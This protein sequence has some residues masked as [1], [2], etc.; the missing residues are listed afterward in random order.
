MSKR[1]S[2]GDWVWLKPNCGFVGQS[3]RYKMEIQSGEE[4]EHCFHCDDRECK[5]WPT[6]WTVA[7]DGKRYPLHHVSECQMLDEPYVVPPKP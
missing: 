7:I 2:P 5:E 4:P 3:N 6:L 1:R